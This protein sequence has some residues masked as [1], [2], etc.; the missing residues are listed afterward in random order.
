MNSH[1]LF[2]PSRHRQQELNFAATSF[3]LH[4]TQLHA[5]RNCYFMLV[6]NCETQLTPHFSQRYTLT[7]FWETVCFAVF[8]VAPVDEK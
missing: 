6:S 2:D 7:V 8:Q 5:S 1:L 3:D 4:S